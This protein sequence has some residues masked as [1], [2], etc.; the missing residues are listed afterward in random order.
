MTVSHKAAR[1]GL[2]R[3][4]SL[5]KPQQ[6]HSCSFSFIQCEKA[7]SFFRAA[8]NSTDKKFEPNPSLRKSCVANVDTSVLYDTS[9]N[10]CT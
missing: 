2:Q 8:L 9:Q 4:N 5:P 6:H 10:Y 7:T 1:N 3:R